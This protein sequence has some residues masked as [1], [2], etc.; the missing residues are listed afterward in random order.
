MGTK[1]MQKEPSQAG[2]SLTGTGEPTAKGTL[3]DQEATV[4]AKA[5][6]QGE[7]GRARERIAGDSLQD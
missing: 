6:W 2:L 1:G 3:E 7:Q 5:L 4:C